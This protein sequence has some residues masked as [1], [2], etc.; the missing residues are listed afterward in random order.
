MLVAANLSNDYRGEC[1][2]DEQDR[3][4][5]GDSGIFSEELDDFRYSACGVSEIKY[6]SNEFDKDQ[7][8][9]G[10]AYASPVSSRLCCM[11]TCFLWLYRASAV[12]S[13]GC[14]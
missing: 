7:H 6:D 9:L 8:D 2:S 13:A 11:A 5:Q 10:H 12:C 1:S 4:R 14:G 3:R